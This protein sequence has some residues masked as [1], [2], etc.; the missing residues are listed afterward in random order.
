MAAYAA[1]AANLYAASNGRAVRS[2]DSKNSYLFRGL[3]FIT[4]VPILVTLIAQSIV[5]AHSPGA[6]WESELAVCATITLA[7]TL[8][9]IILNI[10][11]HRT[12]KVFGQ[13]KS[14]LTPFK[15][16]REKRALRKLNSTNL[17]TFFGLCAVVGYG[18]RLWI[19]GSSKEV[20]LNHAD[21][22]KITARDTAVLMAMSFLE[23]IFVGVAAAQAADLFN[24]SEV[25][26]TSPFWNEMKTT[27]AKTKTLQ[28]GTLDRQFSS[29]LGTDMSAG[30]RM[31]TSGDNQSG[32]HPAT[33][34]ATIER[35]KKALEEEAE[36]M[37]GILQL[38]EEQAY[39]WKHLKTMTLKEFTTFPNPIS[40]AEIRI[41]LAVMMFV[42]ALGPV[43]DIYAGSPVLYW[44]VTYQ[45][46]TRALFGIRLGRFFCRTLKRHFRL[47]QST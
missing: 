4:V 18:I 6:N 19:L 15:A 26:D 37:K 33:N 20:H 23:I 17:F 44:V 39:W 31:T 28:A 46:V 47:T 34:R 29:R 35:E 10:A 12:L 14:A 27:V 43:L 1:I 21:P 36:W 25:K 2:Q 45:L 8:I 42:C 13:I 7:V 11:R 40:E 30:S 9:C 38:S 22:T 24:V 16:K 32:P 5:A 3:L 41:W